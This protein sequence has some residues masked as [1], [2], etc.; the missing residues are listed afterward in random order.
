MTR[1]LAVS[2]VLTIASATLRADDPS[3][4][5]IDGTVV[6]EAGK[7]VVGATIRA[8]QRWW[9]HPDAT[10]ITAADGRFRLELDAPLANATAVYAATRDGARQGQHHTSSMDLAR[11]VACRI[12]L[13]PAA[14][15]RITV[16][17]G[18]GTAVP[19][20]VVALD[21]AEEM[22]AHAITDGAGSTVMRVPADA[23]VGVVVAFKGGVGFDY[24]ENYYTSAENL[25]PVPAAVKLVLSGARTV[26]MRASDSADRPLAGIP[27]CP[28]LV[29]KK[30][31]IARVISTTFLFALAD[32]G[33]LPR[34]GADGIAVCDWFPLELKRASPF[35]PVIAGFHCPASPYFDQSTTTVEPARLLRIAKAGGRVTGPDGAPVAGIL[36]GAAGRGNTNKNCSTDA[37]TAAGGTYSLELYPD[38]EYVVAVVDP[39]RAAPNITGLVIREGRPRT[40]LD[41]HLGPG[42]LVEGNVT[43]GANGEPA[44]GE[45]VYLKTLGAPLS[46]ELGKEVMGTRPGLTRWATIDSAGR[47]R[48]RVGPGEYQIAGPDRT[49]SALD[50]GP[51]GAVAVRRDF[52]LPRLMNDGPIEVIA[53]D[54]DGTPAAGAT[55]LC[56]AFD[57]ARTDDAGRFRGTRGRMPAL[58]YAYD[59]S[60]G[61]AAIAA[62]GPDDGRATLT[63]QPAARA[64]GRVVGADGRPRA[65]CSVTAII[66][67]ATNGTPEQYVRRTTYG[68]VDGS[69]TLTGLVDGTTCEIIVCSAMK[70]GVKPVKK[71]DVRGTD[72]ID[73]GDLVLP[74]DE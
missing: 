10:A 50:V 44:V 16:V 23:K 56:R 61:G 62:I 7:P 29:G 15:V 19:G 26:R 14:T 41:F 33:A 6:D 60:N 30:G 59:P 22:L 48:L 2:V 25:M 9:L 49:Y 5:V 27:F 43:V 69:V 73:L 3:K 68:G 4:A 28:A 8:R 51:E 57:D 34:S 1:L 12:V 52:H 66:R 17:D 70:C 39:D 67:P 63:L 55:L 53:R 54:P 64:T 24:F 18:R 32:T 45:T 35:E 74:P 71:F 20:A 40:D 13:R 46:E 21:D 42:V 47:Y 38:Q 31:K 11:R 65:D 72:P 36:V 37:R 58:V